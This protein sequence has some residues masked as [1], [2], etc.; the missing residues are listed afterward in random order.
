MRGADVGPPAMI[1]AL[2]AFWAGLLYDEGALDAAWDLVRDWSAEDR[3]RLRAEV[4]RPP[5]SA[6]V[7]GQPLRAVAREVLALARAGLARRANRDDAGRD[8]TGF[9]DP[10]DAIAESGRT[11]AERLLDLYAGPR[12]GR[13]HGAARRSVSL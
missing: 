10:L 2:P 1:A 11:Q 6:T 3:E 4:P 7:A 12:D 5:L 13:G 8:E 9:L